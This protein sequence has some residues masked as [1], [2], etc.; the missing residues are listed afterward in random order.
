M[1][2]ETRKRKVLTD[3]FHPSPKSMKTSSA[4]PSSLEQAVPGLSLY[5]NFVTPE[6]ESSILNFLNSKKCTWR[7][8]LS[9]KTMHFGGEYCLMPPKITTGLPKSTD[10]KQGTEIVIKPQ[11]I[12]A[13]PMPEELSWLIQRM[14]EQGIYAKDQVPQYCIVNHYTGSLG[15]SAHTENFSFSEPVVG[16]SL[17]SPCSMRFHELVSPDG[18]SVRSGKAQD[19]KK[20][21]RWKDVMLPGKSLIVMNGD[22]RWKWQHEIVRSRRGRGVGWE[23]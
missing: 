15:I 8:D 11:I 17:L 6:E 3:F 14:T 20:T 18:G 9:R 16:L 23:R 7:T 5:K 12:Q 22:A 19:A 21:G 4:P 13:P 1:D 2:L 10:V